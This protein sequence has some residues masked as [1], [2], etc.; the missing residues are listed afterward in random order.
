MSEPPFDLKQGHHWFAVG[1]TNITWAYVEADSIS[2]H[3]AEKVIHAAHGACFHWL[4]VG[5]LLNHL[6]AQCL[7]ASAYIAAGLPTD[8]VRHARKCLALSFEADAA[9]PGP[10]R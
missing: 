10:T 5:D 9:W 3:E 2:E 6:R 8:A 1:L 4:E 7:L